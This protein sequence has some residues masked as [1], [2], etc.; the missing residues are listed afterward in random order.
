[1]EEITYLFDIT[2]INDVE[3]AVKAAMMNIVEGCV[4]IN[5]T[6]F[7]QST[8]RIN[9]YR[10]NLCSDD[11][12]ID[13]LQQIRVKVINLTNSTNDE[14]N[15]IRVYVYDTRNL[16]DE[17]PIFAFENSKDLLSHLIKA[18]ITVF[19]ENCEN[20]RIETQSIEID[21]KLK[22][23]DVNIPLSQ[24]RYDARSSSSA[25][26]VTHSDIRINGLIKF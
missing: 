23:T 13:D 11:S 20:I 2:H 26:Y 3:D 1:M 4:F 21:Q 18:D 12:D 5:P 10:V 14:D 24:R 8:H 7:T 16:H 15:D 19:H 17:R 25:K 6:G 9:G 22:V